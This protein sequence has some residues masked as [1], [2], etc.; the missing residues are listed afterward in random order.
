MQTNNYILDKENHSIIFTALNTNNLNEIMDLCIETES[1]SVALTFRDFM[2][3]TFPDNQ[4]F[5]RQGQGFPYVVYKGILILSTS[6]DKMKEEI[7][8]LINKNKPK[9]N[10]LHLVPNEQEQST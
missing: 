1:V 3:V 2:S 4:E 10:V 8:S 9:D 6:A 5:H 7:E